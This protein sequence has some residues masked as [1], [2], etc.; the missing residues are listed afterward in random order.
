MAK[1]IAEDIKKD[2]EEMREKARTQGGEEKEA[3]MVAKARAKNNEGSW[4]RYGEWRGQAKARSE[5]TKR[6]EKK[7]EDL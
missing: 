5:E 1:K 2:L 7:L 4:R 6:L 3:E